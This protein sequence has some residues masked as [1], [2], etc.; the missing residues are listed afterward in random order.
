MVATMSSISPVRARSSSASRASPPRSRVV[1][2]SSPT[3][4]KRSSATAMTDAAIHHDLA[5]AGQP[6]S[7]LGAGPVE[8][9]GDGSPPVDD[10]GVRAGVLDV[11][12]ADAPGR[13]VLL[14][15]AP[16][17]QGSWAV[18]Q[19]RHPP[20]ERGHVVEVRIPCGNRGPA[21]A[22]RLAAAS[23]PV[24]PV[25]DR[26]RLLSGNLGIGRG[27]GRAHSSPGL[28]QRHA[29]KRPRKSPR[30]FRGQ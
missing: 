2:A 20:G 26:V 17:E 25:R 11:A 22:S 4:P 1:P 27:S 29:Q 12:A 5:P 8:G 21:A 14:V 7:V 9:D 6:E 28:P 15:D 18:R 10:D 30:T 19:E 13:A 23:P 3:P 24:T 16:E